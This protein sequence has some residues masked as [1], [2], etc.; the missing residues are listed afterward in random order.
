MKRK[1][2]AAYGVIGGLAGFFMQS[3]TVGISDFDT[4]SPWTLTGIGSVLGIWLACSIKYPRALGRR[5]T[6]LRISLPVLLISSLYLL[7]YTGFPGVTASAIARQQWAAH[8]FTSYDGIVN[9]FR[10]C[11]PVLKR[12][13]S[14]QFVAPTQG[15]NVV[16]QELG[17]SGH[18]GEL[19]LE[20]VGESGSGIASLEIGH[21]NLMPNTMQFTH[22]G[23]V[24]TLSCFDP[25]P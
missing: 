2:L 18:H 25:Y 21:S 24:E 20:V 19:T 17:S 7:N 23:K 3:P 4:L 14:I 9:S 1:P 13:G 5:V 6:L 16:F 12:V 15:R 8:E 10:S 22:Q 11:K